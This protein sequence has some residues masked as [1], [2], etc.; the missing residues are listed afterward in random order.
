MFQITLK[1]Y[2][3]MFQITLKIA[4]LGHTGSELKNDNDLAHLY[5]RIRQSRRSERPSVSSGPTSCR[6]RRTRRRRYRTR[7]WSTRWRRRS[8][9]FACH[10]GAEC[11]DGI[12]RS[13][14]A[15]CGCPRR[16]KRSTSGPPVNNTQFNSICKQ[17][18]QMLECNVTRWLDYFWI[19][20]Q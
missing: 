7:R 20:G 5:R 10:V 9:S 4:Q 8:S 2:E 15:G 6:P 17:C 19:F 14:C 13:R 12:W 18:D 3:N 11:R 1:M 16:S